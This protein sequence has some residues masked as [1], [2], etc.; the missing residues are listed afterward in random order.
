M[1]KALVVGIDHYKLV[2]SL[3]GAVN[4]AYSVKSMLDRHADGSVNFGVRLM[5]GTGPHDLLERQELKEA[6]RE[7]FAGD[8][9]LAL[10]YFAG[11]GYLEATERLPVRRRL[12]NR[13]RRRTAFRD[14]DTGEPVEFSE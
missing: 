9:E 8:G 11:H 3:S 6:I 5:V 14:Y 12:Q 1:R 10:L 4:D 2:S 7:L 13:R